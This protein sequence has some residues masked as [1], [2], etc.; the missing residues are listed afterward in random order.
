MAAQVRCG[1]RATP[2]GNQYVGKSVGSLRRLLGPELGIPEGAPAVVSRDG[3]M[4]S[5]A[6]GDSHPLDHGELLEFTR[7]AGTKGSL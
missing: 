6:V 1:P 7:A 2:M 5:R 4:T 3:G